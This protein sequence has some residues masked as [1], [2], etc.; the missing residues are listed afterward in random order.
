MADVVVAAAREV[1]QVTNTTVRERLG[2]DRS[3]ALFLLSDLVESGR[4]VR[5][6]R[7]RGTHYVVPGQT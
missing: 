2:V 1:G 3:T 4:L 7:K 5:R 6:G